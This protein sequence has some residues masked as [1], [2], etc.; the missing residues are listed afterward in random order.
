MAVSI[1]LVIN[2]KS[3]SI[4]KQ[5]KI[6]VHKIR[7]VPRERNTKKCDIVKDNFNEMFSLYNLSFPT[8]QLY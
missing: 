1:F 8:K 4:A 2:G 7:Q 6:F 3:V 5:I